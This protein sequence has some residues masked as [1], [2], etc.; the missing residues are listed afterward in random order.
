MKIIFIKWDR[1]REHRPD[2]ILEGM[3]TAAKVLI[4][5]P[6]LKINNLLTKKIREDQLNTEAEVN[7]TGKKGD[8]R[9]VADGTIIYGSCVARAISTWPW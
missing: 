6:G 5:P 4:I 2:G 7:R 3:I 9:W 1:D 8:Y